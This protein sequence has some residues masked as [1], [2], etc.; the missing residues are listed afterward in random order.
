MLMIIFL[1]ATILKVLGA[2]GIALVIVIAGVIYTV[3]LLSPLNP[4]SVARVFSDLRHEYQNVLAGRITYQR[5]LERY[6]SEYAF[7]DPK[8]P[9]ETR[10]AKNEASF[11]VKEEAFL[12]MVF[13]REG[14]LTPSQIRALWRTY[15]SKSAGIEFSDE[16]AISQEEIE[17]W[18][19]RSFP[20]FISAVSIPNQK[21]VIELLD[22]LV[23]EKG[24]GNNP[25]VE[26]YAYI[27]VLVRAQIIEAPSFE[28]LQY[29]YPGYTEE[30]RKNYRDL[31]GD[32]YTGDLYGKMIKKAQ[33][34]KMTKAANYFTAI[35]PSNL[36]DDI[37]IKEK[38]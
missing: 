30:K 38:D 34:D 26:E 37:R 10:T 29:T 3:W 4:H 28:S 12:K 15:S 19:A 33:Y 35:I 6:Y 18:R 14:V 11:M 20:K 16:A 21:T 13:D 23:E 32:N 5:F 17:A 27:A 31:L 1:V 24:F 25:G 9:S 7:I 22:R 36:L 8:D 2:L